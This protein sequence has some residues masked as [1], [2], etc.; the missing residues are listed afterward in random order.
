MSGRTVAGQISRLRE[1]YDT[2]TLFQLGRQLR[3]AARTA[4]GPAGS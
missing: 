2:D 4:D 3:A 1:R